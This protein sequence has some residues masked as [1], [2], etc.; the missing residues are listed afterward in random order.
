MINFVTLLIPFKRNEFV[1]QFVA[2]HD[3]N[4]ALIEA[5]PEIGVALYGAVEG[6]NSCPD[7]GAAEGLSHFHRLVAVEANSIYSYA[8]LGVEAHQPA[9]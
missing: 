8:E 2:L 3:G 4:T 5:F 1:E 6:D 7:P 9:A